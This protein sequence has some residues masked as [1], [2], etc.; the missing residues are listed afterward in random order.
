MPRH[1]LTIGLLALTLLA[2]T[3]GRADRAAED[4]PTAAPV[5]IIALDDTVNPATAEFV[6]RSLEQAAAHGAPLVVLIVDTPGGLVESMRAMVRAILASPTPVAVW[7]GPSGARATSAGAFLVLAGH[8]AAMAPASH[9]GAA[10]PVAGGGQEIEGVMAKKAASDL[11]ALAAS[12]AKDRGRDAK[13][14]QLMVTEAKSYDAAQAQELGLI[15]LRADD[16]AELLQKLDGRKARTATGEKTI[17]TAG[18]PQRHEQPTWLDKVLSFLANPN[19]AYLLLMIGLAGVYLEFSHPGAVLPGVVG[20]LCLLFAFFAM[21]VLPVSSLGLALIALAVVLFIVEIKVTSFGLLSLAGALCL[22]FGSL[23]LFDF[24]G[25]FVELSLGVMT[26]VVAAV[27]AFFAG[28]AY[29]AGRAQMATSATGAEGL[30]GARGRVSRR[31]GWVVVRGELWRARGA[32]GLAADAAVVV[33]RLDGL[34]LVVE[35]LADETRA[36]ET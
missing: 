8:V 16:L 30:I 20:A 31:A 9:L 32:E 36:D 1:W 15:D 13:A 7:V 33:R 24:E 5:W 6:R 25:D 29:L 21:S 19:M 26:P 18:R 10:A 17:Q 34:E 2:A 28:V 35:P 11:S 12:L 4:P 22:V 3:S 14:A 27:I 23:M